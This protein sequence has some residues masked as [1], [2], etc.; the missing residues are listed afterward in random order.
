MTCQQNSA[1]APRSAT[2]R[3]AAANG[4]VESSR[5]GHRTFRAAIAT[6]TQPVDVEASPPIGVAD[7]FAGSWW[8]PAPWV[9]SRLSARRRPRGRTP[10][11]E[12]GT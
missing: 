8:A 3:A 9:G 2:G 11:N 12:R 5:S 4:E 10:G 6:A 7:P 1:G